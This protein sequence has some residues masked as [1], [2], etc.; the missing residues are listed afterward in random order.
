M[1]GINTHFGKIDEEDRIR[2]FSHFIRSVTSHL[3]THALTGSADT[4]LEIPNLF[5]TIATMSNIR[6]CMYFKEDMEKIIRHVK[7]G[8]AY[9]QDGELAYVVEEEFMKGIFKAIQQVHTDHLAE[10]K[11][12]IW[13][14]REELIAAVFLPERAW[15]IAGAHSMEPMDWLIA[16]EGYEVESY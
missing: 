14:I 9:D 13:A 6:N 16:N 15:R 3:R 8:V 4:F 1:D 10:R 12:R 11:Q 2:Y 5:R 7:K